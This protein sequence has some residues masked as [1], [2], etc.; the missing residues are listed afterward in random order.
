MTWSVSPRLEGSAFR[1][2]PS[3]SWIEH[4][5]PHVNRCVCAS[6]RWLQRFFRLEAGADVNAVN[7][8]NVAWPIPDSV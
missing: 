1:L 5:L 3:G 8:Q 4:R 7:K 2:N 6:S